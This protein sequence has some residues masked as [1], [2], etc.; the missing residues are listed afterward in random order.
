MR[1]TLAVLAIAFTAL[2]SSG[3]PASADPIDLPGGVNASQ[4]C[5]DHNDFFPTFETHGACVTAWHKNDNTFLAII[6]K[7]PINQ[8]FAGTDNQGQ[9]MKFFRAL[10]V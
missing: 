2:I 4:F 6:C 5:T 8:Q 7:D 9:C 3:V 10:I 1:R